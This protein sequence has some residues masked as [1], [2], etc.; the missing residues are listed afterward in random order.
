MHR[1]SILGV[2]ETTAFLSDMSCCICR[3]EMSDRKN[4]TRKQELL[5]LIINIILLETLSEHLSFVW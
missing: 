4:V 5:K 3:I 1:I 2:I